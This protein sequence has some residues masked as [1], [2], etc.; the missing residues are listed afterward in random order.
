[1]QIPFADFLNHDGISEADV[2]FDE[3]KQLSEVS[4]SVSLTLCRTVK[5][6]EPLC[7]VAV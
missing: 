4:L 6:I 7:G 1:M 5:L 3:A 2:L